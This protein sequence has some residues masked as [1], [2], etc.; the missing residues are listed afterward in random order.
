MKYWGG[1][2]GIAAVMSDYGGEHGDARYNTYSFLFVALDKHGPFQSHMDALRQKHKIY[3]PYSE[4]KYKDLKV[5]LGISVHR[6]H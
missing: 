4:F 2:R 5:G 3:V 1:K 6:A